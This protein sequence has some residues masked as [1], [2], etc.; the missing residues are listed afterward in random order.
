MIDNWLPLVIEQGQPVILSSAEFWYLDCGSG[1][2]LLGSQ[3]QSWCL[4]R[5]WQRGWF[6]LRLYH[7]YLSCTFVSIAFTDSNTHK[8]YSC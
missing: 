6:L 1:Q 7:L 2:W 5:S 8:Q 3:R 4:F